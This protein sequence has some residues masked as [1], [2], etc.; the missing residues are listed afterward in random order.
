MQI[1]EQG[2]IRSVADVSRLNIIDWGRANGLWRGDVTVP[3]QIVGT[4]LSNHATY[5]I[6]EHDLTVYPDRNDWPG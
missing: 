2:P 1:L 3:L 6:L 5:T 4:W